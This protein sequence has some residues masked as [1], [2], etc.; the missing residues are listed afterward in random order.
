MPD[1]TQNNRRQENKAELARRRAQSQRDKARNQREKA[2]TEARILLAIQR[3]LASTST[4]TPPSNNPTN[5]AALNEEPAVTT[6]ASIMEEHS[7][8]LM[9]KIA[10]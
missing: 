8:M 5:F 4:L 2:R 7:K 6:Q 9:K 10:G 3:D 1:R